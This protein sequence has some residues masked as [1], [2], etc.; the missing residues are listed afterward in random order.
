MAGIVGIEPTPRGLEAL[1][2]PLHYIPA[3]RRGFGPRFLAS[4]ANVL[5]VGRTGNEKG[6]H[7]RRPFIKL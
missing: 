1:V 3:S 2:L 7:L 4:K 5:P 6:L